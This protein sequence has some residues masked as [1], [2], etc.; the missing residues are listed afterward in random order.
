MIKE[1]KSI[2]DICGKDMPSTIS[3]ESAHR[4]YDFTITSCGKA[5]EKIW[6]ICDACRRDFKKWVKT[7]KEVAGNECQT[8]RKKV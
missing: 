6:D 5:P 8:E 4:K 2:C 1:S 3:V 7:R